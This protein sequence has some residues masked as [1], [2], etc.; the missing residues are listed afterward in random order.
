[1]I[2]LE[3]RDRAY[4]SVACIGWLTPNSSTLVLLH[5]LEMT[6]ELLP[7]FSAAHSR[8]LLLEHQFFV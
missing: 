6:V 3:M 4:S 1:M 7:A 5:H 2:V 8:F